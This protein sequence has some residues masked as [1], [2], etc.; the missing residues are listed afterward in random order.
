MDQLWTKDKPTV[1]V[2]NS[3]VF[4]VEPAEIFRSRIGVEQI[5]KTARLA[6]ARPPESQ[7]ASATEEMRRQ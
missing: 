7:E 6:A 4:Q 5:L 3:G 2:S 1:T